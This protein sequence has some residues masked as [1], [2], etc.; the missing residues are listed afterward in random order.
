MDDLRELDRLWGGEA[1][2]SA[3]GGRQ[4]EIW[5]TESNPADTAETQRAQ[6]V[7]VHLSTWH[8]PL[9]RGVLFP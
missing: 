8:Q 7:V 5:H 1:T 2:I 6:V 3:S 9:F 4:M